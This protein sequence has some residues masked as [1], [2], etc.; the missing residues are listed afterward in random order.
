MEKLSNQQI[1][2]I[3]YDIKE[4]VEKANFKS[5]E[6]ERKIKHEAFLKT[7]KGKLAK[8]YHKTFGSNMTPNFLDLHS[9]FEPKPVYLDLQKIRNKV[10]LATIDCKDYTELSNKLL[11]E[12]LNK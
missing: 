3:A 2:A 12:F 11:K 7:T 6:I 5:N 8:D 9:N 4:K 10:I 1:D